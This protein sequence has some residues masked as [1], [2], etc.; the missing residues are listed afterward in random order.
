MDPSGAADGGLTTLELTLAPSY[1]ALAARP[2]GLSATA[3]LIFTALG[4]PALHQSIAVSFLRVAP[5]R[6]VSKKP[7]SRRSRAA[8]PAHS[9]TKG[10]RGR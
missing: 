1:R 10:H 5:K 2:G 9:K 8:V 6:P 7:V 3:N 4:H